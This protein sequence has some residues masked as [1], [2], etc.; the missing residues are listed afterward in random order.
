MFPKP[1]TLKEICDIFIDDFVREESVDACGAGC[2]RI[3]TYHLKDNVSVKNIEVFWID[4]IK[5]FAESL[6]MGEKITDCNDRCVGV[7][8]AECRWKNGADGVIRE[9]NTKLDNFLK[10]GG[11]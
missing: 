7:V 9:L 2:C 8:C 3:K 6:R 1:Q 11:V 10:G 5:Q 4:V